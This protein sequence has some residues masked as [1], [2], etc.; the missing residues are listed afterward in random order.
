MAASQPRQPNPG[1]AP[2][3][4]LVLAAIVISGLVVG[5]ALTT[6]SGTPPSL[7]ASVRLP[8]VTS[9]S[10]TSPPPSTIGSPGTSVT[11]GA[12]NVV[13]AP[14]PVVTQ[15]NG[16]TATTVPVLTT[17]STTEDGSG[18]HGTTTTTIEPGDHER[19][20]GST[21]GSTTSTTSAAAQDR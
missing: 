14:K 20:H 16:Q 1:R 15:V 8:A 18:S 11:T 19:P 4:S 7:P 9:V 10:T 6:I 5:F 17:T 2:L 12:L 3:W 21:P 13:E